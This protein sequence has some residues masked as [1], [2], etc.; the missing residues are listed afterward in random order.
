LRRADVN[1][2]RR[3][4]VTSRAM[5]AALFRR[6]GGPEVMEVG[7]IPTPTPGPGEVQ[8]RVGAAGMNH[9]ALWMRQGVPALRVAWP[10]VAGGDVCGVISAIGPGVKPM[11]DLG[12]GD[13]A[14]VNPSL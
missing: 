12:E 3:A 1:R 8:I 7:D 6:H 9:L 4:V 2:A 5:R 13:R 10:Q 11:A 14:V